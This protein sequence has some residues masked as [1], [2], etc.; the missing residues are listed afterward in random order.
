MHIKNILIFITYMCILITDPKEVLGL[1]FL[2]PK[3]KK[4]IRFHDV[5]LK[6]HLTNEEKN[7]QYN[8]LKKI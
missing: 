1:K 5:V 7:F 2:P 6:N 4:K 8:K 3:W